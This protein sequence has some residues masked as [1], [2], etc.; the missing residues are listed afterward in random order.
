MPMI[1][2]MDTITLQKSHQS[3]RN[4][5]NR[6]LSDIEVKNIEDVVMQTSSSCFFQVVSVIRV[7]DPKKKEIIASLSGGQD[8]IK[9]CAEFWMFCMDFT[10]LYHINS[11]LLNPLPFKL[12]YSGLTDVSLCCQNALIAA[13]AQGLGGVVIGGY[14][15]GIREVT[16]LLNLPKYVVPA[17]GLCLGAVDK[18]YLEEQKPR[19]PKDWVF[20]TDEYQDNFTKDGLDNYDKIMNQYYLNRK[21]GSRDS[22]WSKSAIAMMPKGYEASDDLISYLKEQGFKFS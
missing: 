20:F 15:D 22:N 7:K 6:E 19:M 12:F 3:V 17:L 4:Y 5:L 8:H 14:K 18:E 16:K 10:K 13:E 1:K 9:N 11:N 2:C 21:Y